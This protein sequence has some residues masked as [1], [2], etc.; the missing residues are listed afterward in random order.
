MKKIFKELFLVL[1]II[2]AIE[3]T[4]QVVILIMLLAAPMDG[5]RISTKKQALGWFI[6]AW[7]I[8][9]AIEELP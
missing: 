6:P 7:P 8:Y 1:S 5:E 3:Y 4:F 2:L 9:H